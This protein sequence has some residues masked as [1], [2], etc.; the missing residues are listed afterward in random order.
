MIRF[1]TQPENYSHWK[2]A[3]DGPVSTLT[4]VVAEDK[5]LYPGY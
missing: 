1:E 5:G 3:F 4:L 2:L